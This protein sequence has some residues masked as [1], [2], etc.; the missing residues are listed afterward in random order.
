M[1][2]LVV[3]D[4]EIIGCLDQFN[5]IFKWNFVNVSSLNEIIQR[6]LVESFNIIDFSEILIKIVS[7]QNFTQE[8]WTEL[9]K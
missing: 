6:V 9:L 3:S 5:M 4:F 2:I 1:N 8:N 7:S